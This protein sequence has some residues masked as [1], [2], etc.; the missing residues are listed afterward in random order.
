VGHERAEYDHYLCQSDYPLS[1]AN[2]DNL[3][4][5][6]D[7]CN[8]KAN[9]GDKNVIAR[10]GRNLAYYPYGVSS[11]VEVVA[12]CTDAQEISR[13]PDWKVAVTSRKPVDEGEKVET[14]MWVY[15][16]KPRYEESLQSDG[17]HWV[18]MMMKDWVKGGETVRIRDLRRLFNEKANECGAEIEICEGA[19]V[20]EA[21]CRFYAK[22][23]SAI[24]RGL[25]KNYSSPYGD[26][27]RDRGR[28]ALGAVA[29]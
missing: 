25:E 7:R 5:V 18:G 10:T 20:K 12:E 11:G 6:C 15:R 29:A 28:N 24:L 13:T 27:V 8:R 9:K 23:E 3:F 26:Y 21:L 22:A 2:W 1:I 4:P 14:W 19:V 16:I 17:A